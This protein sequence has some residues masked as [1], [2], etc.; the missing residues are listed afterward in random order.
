MVTQQLSQCD[1]D[2]ED[3]DLRGLDAVVLCIIE[4]QFDDRVAE[5]VLDQ[6]VD[7]VDP[8]SEDFITQIEALAHLAVLGAESGQHPYRAVG[9]RTV[10]AIDERA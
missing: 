9:D 6:G 7:C 3:G 4:N 5:L 10:G 2:G 8:V 1:L